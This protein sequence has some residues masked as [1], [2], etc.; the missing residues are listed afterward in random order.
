MQS[1][2]KQI[3]DLTVHHLVIL[4]LLLKGC[5][6]PSQTI[7]LGGVAGAGVGAISGGLAD[8]GKDGQYRTRNVVIGSALGGAAGLLTGALVSDA[9]E[10]GRA[11]AS[12]KTKSEHLIGAPLLKDPRVEARWVET[13]VVGNR[14]IEGHFEYQIIEPAQWEARQ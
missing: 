13:K 9:I 8:P 3:F 1:A 12:K 10:T 2:K 6:T 4:S 5:A 14:Y 7:G 11:Q